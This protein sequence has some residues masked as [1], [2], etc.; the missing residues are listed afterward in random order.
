MINYTIFYTYTPLFIQGAGLTLALW[1]VSTGISLVI[2]VIWGIARCSQLR[3]PVISL[4]IDWVT[5][6]LRGV[7]FYV[8]LLVVYFVL[9]ALLGVSLPAFIAAVVSLGLCSAAY[10]SQMIRGGI[11]ALP[12]GQWAAARALGYS[13]GQTLWFVIIPQ[14]GRAV[15]PSL[16]GECDQLL[17]STSI[18]STIG[19]LDVTRAG[20]NIVARTMDPVPVYCAIVC[21]YLV[22]SSGL[23]ILG[24]YLERGGR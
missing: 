5:F 1:L 21:I 15:L 19:V 8:Q 23:N 22:M 13:T 16:V 11:N 7:P 18:V 24:W 10:V 4:G 9:P 14:M 3:L 17:K 20:M 12:Q 2:G 6:V